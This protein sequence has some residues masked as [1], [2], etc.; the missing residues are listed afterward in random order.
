MLLVSLGA[1]IA[2][3]GMQI[4]KMGSLS[5]D[6]RLCGKDFVSKLRVAEQILCLR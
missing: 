1:L 2:I 5:F 4:I 3:K 6:Q